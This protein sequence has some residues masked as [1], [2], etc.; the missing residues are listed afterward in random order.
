V[1]KRRIHTAK[2]KEKKKKKKLVRLV[3][4][5]EKKRTDYEGE[6]KKKEKG[7]FPIFSREKGEE[8][9]Y[10]DPSGKGIG[11]GEKMTPTPRGRRGRETG[12]KGWILHISVEKGKRGRGKE[13]GRREHKSSRAGP[14][15]K[16]GEGKTRQNIILSNEKGGRGMNPST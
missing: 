12:K 14:V 7:I 15:K 13:G 1:G 4:K 11:G 6:E 2:K 16:R 3:G 9:L 8:G 5:T 10:H